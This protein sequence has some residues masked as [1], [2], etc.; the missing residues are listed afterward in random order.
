MPRLDINVANWAFWL[1]YILSCC[2]LFPGVILVWNI[3]NQVHKI[4]F[5]LSSSLFVVVLLP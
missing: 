2:S 4:A 1:I 5:S 3:H